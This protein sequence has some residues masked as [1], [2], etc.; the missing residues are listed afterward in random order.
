MRPPDCL[1]TERLRL[2]PIALDDATAIFTTYAREDAPTKFMDWPRHRSLAD[3]ESFTQ[4]CV[5]CWQTGSTF[6]W[7]ITDRMTGALMG[8]LELRLAPPKADFGYLLA[9]PYWRQGFA[10]EA[11][12]VV[13][14]WAMAQPSIFRVWATCHPDNLASAAVLRKAG[15]SYETT[16]PSWA[17][18]P[19]LGEQA[20]PRQFYALIKPTV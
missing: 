3:S 2:R 11:A 10:T 15:L 1:E 7:A 16:L 6:P 19:Q 20:S 5:E 17:H 4:R 13:V 9:E 8:A 12:R 14:A 18:G